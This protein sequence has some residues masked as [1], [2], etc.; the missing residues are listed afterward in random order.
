VYSSG[1]VSLFFAQN[2]S[3]TGSGPAQLSLSSARVTITAGATND[4]FGASVA[5]IGDFTGDERSDIAILR[6]DGAGEF[7]QVGAVYVFAGRDQLNPWPTSITDPDNAAVFVV[8]HSDTL[9]SYSVRA[10]GNVMGDARTELLVT[11]HFGSGTPGGGPSFLVA[12]GSAPTFGSP[13]ALHNVVPLGDIDDDGYD[14]LGASFFEPGRAFFFF[15]GEVENAHRVGHVYRG[16][17]NGPNF[18]RPDFVLETANPNYLSSPDDTARLF[19]I[20]SA[21]DID[22]D[23]HSEFA[24]ADEPGGVL[25]V[26][27]GE[28]LLPPAV[29]ATPLA[30]PA[31]VPFTYDLATP[32]LGL[33][34]TTSALALHDPNPD[35]ASANVVL[36]TET[37]RVFSQIV[38][39]GASLGD[40]NGDGFDDFFFGGT[41]TGRI[42][43]GPVRIEGQTPFIDPP[44]IVINTA[45]MGEL[46]P[47]AGDVNNDGTNDLVF[48]RKNAQFDFTV[49]VI[50]GRDDLPSVLDE[51]LLIADKQIE[52]SFGEQ[53]FRTTQPRVLDWNG[54]GFSD[55]VVTSDPAAANST[56]DVARVY[57]GNTITNSPTKVVNESSARLLRIRPDSTVL[58]DEMAAIFGANWQSLGISISDFNNSNSGL[59]AVV[60]GDVNGDGLEDVLFVNR[61]FLEVQFGLN[62]S[63]ELSRSYLVLGQATSLVTGELDLAQADTIFQDSRAFNVSP[64]GDING[65]G[66]DDL[67]FAGIEENSF[68]GFSALSIVHGSADPPDFN[69]LRLGTRFAAD[70]II[71]RFAPGVL[72]D[73]ARV[74]SILMATAGDF[75]G[76][77]RA[78]LALGEL[79]R[80]VRTGGGNIISQD[81]RGHLYVF[82]AINDRPAEVFFADADFVVH[83]EAAI[84]F[85]G[86]LPQ[87]PNVDLDGDGIHDL[88]ATAFDAN[89]VIDGTFVPIG[90]KVY[91]IYGSRAPGNLPNSGIQPLS[92][93]N[94]SGS[95]DFLVDR[96]TGQPE[97]FDVEIDA[98]KVEQWFRFTTLGDGQPGN[99]IRLSPN[100]P[101]QTIELQPLAAGTLVG[102]AP[103][104]SPNP[105]VPIVLERGVKRGILEFDLSPYLAFRD[106]LNG[107]LASTLSLERTLVVPPS[108][109]Q[110]LR[111][112]VLNGEGDGWLNIGDASD[113][114]AVA[115]SFDFS[116]PIPNVIQVDLL[117][118]VRTAL[119]SGLTRITLRLEIVGATGSGSLGIT[120]ASLDVSEAEQTGVLA[121]LHDATGA[122]LASGKD[123]IDMQMLPAGTYFLRAYNPQGAQPDALPFKISFD[124]PQAGA[125]HPQT[126]H[127]TLRGGDSNDV[128]IGNRQLDR[129]FGEGGVD[130]FV[131]ETVE[132]RDLEAGEVVN[133]SHVPPHQLIS[134]FDSRHVPQNP[135][136][137]IPDSNLRA[138][139]VEQLGIP[140]TTSHTGAPIPA[141]PLLASDLATLTELDLTNRGIVDLSGLEF[142]TN[143]RRLH[144]GWNHITDLSPLA[145]P[146]GSPLG[147]ESLEILTLDANAIGDLSPLATLTRL[148]ALSLDFNP[149][150]DIGPL[151]ALINLEF[152]SID[153]RM[154]TELAN[155]QPG[156]VTGGFGL[157]VELTNPAEGVVALGS[158]IATMDNRV[159]VGAHG[160]PGL[161][162]QG[163]VVHGA[164]AV[165]VFSAITGERLLTI[166]NPR[167]FGTDFFGA[168]VATFDGKI[169]VGAPQARDP[170][171]TINPP[172]IGLVYVFDGVTGT[173]L[174][175]I[176]SPT[177]V[178]QFGT[179]VAVVGSTIA[180]GEP[181]AGK[182][183]FYDGSTGALRSPGGTVSN[184]S[185]VLVPLGGDRLLVGVPGDDLFEGAVYLVNLSAGTTLKVPNPLAATTG[186]MGQS[187]VGVGTEFFAGAPAIG[188]GQIPTLL[189]FNS[190]GQLLN[191]FIVP[192]A[193]TTGFGLS[194]ALVGNHT[195]VAGGP[196]D[197]TG[198]AFSGAVFA[199]DYT[200]PATG[201]KILN[202][203]PAQFD[204]FGTVIAGGG[205]D[206]LIAAPNTDRG[207][208]VNTGSVYVYGSLERG[209]ISDVS[210]LAGLDK[211]RWLSLSSN[212]IA[213]ITPLASLGQ[214]EHLDLHDNAIRDVGPLVDQFLLDDGDDGFTTTGQWSNNVNPAGATFDADYHFTA[215]GAATGTEASW[216]F[217]DLPD[218]VY[219]VQVTWLPGESRTPAATFRVEGADTPST[220]AVDQ[221]FQ[222]N[223]P[224]FGGRTWQSL[225]Q[226][227]VRDGQLI[228]RLSSSL[229]GSIAAD[230]VRL[231]RQDSQPA[232]DGLVQLSLEDNPLSAQSLDVVMPIIAGVTS[233][234][235]FDANPS[236]PTLNPLDGAYTATSS[237]FVLDL[238]SAASDVDGDAISF[239]AESNRPT[240]IV[241]SVDGNNVLTA[242]P[243]QG[244]SGT[245]RITV[246]AHDRRGGGRTTQQRFDLH[247]GTGGIH[248]TKWHDLDQDGKL[249]AGE[250]TLEGWTIFIDANANGQ[251]D[252]SEQFTLTDANG[253]YALN[254][255]P[256]GSYDVAEVQQPGWVLADRQALLAA[257]F[258]GGQPQGFTSAGAA[259]QWHLSTRRGNDAG[260]S[261]TRSF[262]FGDEATGQYTANANGTLISPVIDLTNTTG[263]VTLEFNHFLAANSTPSQAAV[264]Q[265]DFTDAGGG[266]SIE[267]FTS[268][269]LW[270]VSTGRQSDEGHSGPH[271]FY[272]GQSES[273]FGGGEVPR[274]VSGTLLSPLIDLTS[275][276]ASDSIQLSFKHFLDTVTNDPETGEPLVDRDAVSVAVLVG[277]S[278]TV[279]TSH[280]GA[281]PNTFGIVTAQFSLSQFA[282]QQIQIEFR[283]QAGFSAPLLSSGAEGWYVDDITITAPVGAR[284]EVVVNILSGGQRTP[285]A[286]NRTI[287]NLA[288]TPTWQPVTV[289]L[290][291]F[292]GGAIQVEF[293]FTSNEVGQ[294]EGW[295]VDDVLVRAGS[296][297][298]SV[299]LGTG[300]AGVRTGV[301]LGN[302]RVASAGADRT[303]NEGQLVSFNSIV[304][305]PDPANGSNFTYSWQVAADNGQVVP[306]GAGSS[307]NFTPNDNGTYTLTLTVTDLNAGGVRYVDTVRVV[308]NNAAPV[309]NLGPDRVVNE[310]GLIS[311]AN[312]ATDAAGD[313][314]S[315]LWQLINSSGQVISSS[316]NPAFNFT[317][318]DD[319]T[320]TLRVVV[321]DDDAA[322]TTDEVLVTVQNVTPQGVHIGHALA[323]AGDYDRNGIVQQADHS[324]WRQQFGAMSG[325]GLQA[326]GNGNGIVDAAD[327][328]VWRKKLTTSS[329][330]ANAEGTPVLLTASY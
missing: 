314:L 248:G 139:I 140:T 114:F 306:G 93:F 291:A 1:R 328:V 62:A 196:S 199:F 11:S 305:D 94:V 175:T 150:A 70:Q 183:H 200:N 129:L 195:V 220:I 296:Q 98:R 202:P 217:D 138:A 269:G 25:H 10:A 214:L 115:G 66:Y 263:P 303:V 223:G 27:R 287:G 327:F 315:Y 17:E 37:Q 222:P 142:A 276:S 255:L 182:I 15:G 170:N 250:P 208:V 197:N 181:N 135:V 21:G 61:E 90:G 19:L 72:A 68:T 221:R 312:P 118:A 237:P 108:I 105:D 298:A 297:A 33:E 7:G 243:R 23:G 278:R 132:V 313:S 206:L 249:D 137:D 216:Q 77:G 186:N 13:L 59:S 316:N 121:D 317:A 173:L 20:G 193:V 289:D 49:F 107:I 166:N 169:I 151:A 187:L 24:L 42:L 283:Y 167:P 209:S 277:T 30:A 309:V 274:S 81:L 205:N 116:G 96:A 188:F 307:F 304:N 46:A 211:L 241:V 87:S 219:D 106:N 128:L 311:F 134:D 39:P 204:F 124:A 210:A 234:L 120:Q 125:F 31:G 160:T 159:V 236:A 40:I 176:V 282:G 168:S 320:L 92:N 102:N 260:H 133:V 207:G 29:T 295:Y 294:A 184:P 119:A 5:G 254:N 153:G 38:F 50:F 122:L 147:L 89:T 228:V 43:L 246:T 117:D 238:R 35:L 229:T 101:E 76:D 325:V 275:Y 145:G 285:V 148:E 256:S 65:D 83:G 99:H 131:A 225:G 74:N 265:A 299:V 156:G 302:F 251:L 22:G 171:V 36:G 157:L 123:L 323:T 112:S 26:F 60:A 163:Q 261:P 253:D 164:G 162:S 300:P 290:S 91:V 97:M 88:V 8:P 180:V 47:D 69:G 71:Q 271:S 262:Y 100:R 230:A 272:F 58:E 126:D 330:Q 233:G 52:T 111:V 144:L 231:V 245:A 288:N 34:P 154:S 55:I 82:F 172:S 75:D 247:V 80:E 319:V 194:A 226:F 103:E 104:Q 54:D 259:N 9:F 322:M 192:S 67:G 174:H 240:D 212:D 301:N 56:I 14:D 18:A 110:A 321:T 44:A 281:F 324:F 284:D 218:G 270:H 242:T 280:P 48:V 136:V 53:H 130:S 109:G 85:F 95:G 213:N 264:I 203:F 158:A 177:P 239:T 73:G 318:L 279:L 286:G 32:A 57:S 4:G 329:P 326:D 155:L 252:P 232:A 12:A 198:A 127:D 45:T 141:R 152:L 41:P 258:T 190:T 149:I 266:Q 165:Y 179:S 51:P 224:A 191:T 3:S 161:N 143:L 78:D 227:E 84:D 189:H 267:G 178:G 28:D 292:V 308:A 63:V 6:A 257:D 235:T 185:Q 64:L 86:M 244:F 293:S 273:S 268:T 215:G 146:E 16:G 79:T 201:I 310:G 113:E 2:G